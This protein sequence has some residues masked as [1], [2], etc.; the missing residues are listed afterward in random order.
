MYPW[1]CIWLKSTG[2]IQ[3]NSKL[4]EA[5]LPTPSTAQP[6]KILWQKSLCCEINCGW[7]QTEESKLFG[8]YSWK[9]LIQLCMILFSQSKMISYMTWIAKHIQNIKI[10][11]YLGNNGKMK[12]TIGQR[13]GIFRKNFALMQ[14]IFL[15]VTTPSWAW[16]TVPFICFFRGEEGNIRQCNGKRDQSVKNSSM[17]DKIKISGSSVR[18]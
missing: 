8:A 11:L 16:Y 3:L 13:C 1:D 5:L 10:C 7:K 9:W 2:R 14:N 12:W 15:G 17:Q 18:L 4:L 6:N